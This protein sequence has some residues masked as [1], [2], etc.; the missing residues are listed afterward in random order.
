MT[1]VEVTNAD[2]QSVMQANP[3]V[4]LQVENAA[5]KR[6]LEETKAAFDAAM[7][8]NERL[9]IA[10]KVRADSEYDMEVKEK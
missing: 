4:A 5:L 7:M 3:L 6:K 10:T 2:V 1:Q 9:N 8:E